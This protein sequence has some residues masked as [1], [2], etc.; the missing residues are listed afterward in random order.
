MPK[1]QLDY[2][3]KIGAADLKSC[4]K[5]LESKLGT[6]KL[7]T[8]QYA[9]SQSHRDSSDGRSR[10]SVAIA[11]LIDLKLSAAQVAEL[12]GIVNKYLKR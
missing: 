10:G 12:Q 3:G 7:P 5:E 4:F 11:S 6:F 2:E 8:K 1:I 9:C